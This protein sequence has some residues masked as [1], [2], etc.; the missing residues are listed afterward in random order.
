MDHAFRMNYRIRTD[1]RLC[2]RDGLELVLELPSTPLANEFPSAPSKGQEIFPLRLLA[3][4]DCGHVQLPV[5]VDPERL[6]R[7]YVYVSG[8]SPAFIDHFRRYTETLLPLLEARRKGA[9]AP[10][11]V[12]VG[13]NDGTMLRFFKPTYRVLGIDPARDIAAI[14]SGNGVETWPEFLSSDV[15]D[16]VVK[17]FG[18]A[19]LVIANNVFAHA[20]DLR[21]FA[22]AVKSILEP[23]GS[24][25]FEVGYLVD[26]LEKTLVDN[27]YHEHVSYH[28]LAPLIPFFARLGMSLVDA[29][30]IDTHGGSI[31]VRVVNETET[32]SS[33][34]VQALLNYERAKGL[35]NGADS[36]HRVFDEFAENL[37]RKR[38]EL[39]TVLSR[40]EGKR[41]AGYGAP[42]K[43]TT[44]L[45]VLGLESGVFE[46]V[47]EDNPRK[48]GKY[49]P[50]TDVP[51]L[52]SSA[53]L[54]R[55]PEAV[56]ILAWN[57]ADSILS[58]LEEYRARG[59]A[60]IVPLPTL[61]LVR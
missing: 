55:A 47:V 19:S 7:D 30:R 57:F 44:L 38:N 2:G 46:F 42:A 51:V 9:E 8:T 17:R 43:A 16:R 45:R 14:A 29:E 1:C 41:V 52:S 32:S 3:C 10:L 24:F 6:F 59:G 61:R 27:C 58:K 34:R 60:C 26:V 11:V 49:L 15:A 18:G 23:G 36:R 13:S 5:V 4:G 33:G 48:I 31:R 56:V 37:L 35:A 54:D 21:G 39:R 22:S 25:V 53:L 12:E 50:G 20:D 28:H 40:F